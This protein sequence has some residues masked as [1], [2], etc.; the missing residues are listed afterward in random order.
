MANVTISLSGD[1]IEPNTTV[2]TLDNGDRFLSLRFGDATV[3]I[4]GLNA[5]AAA[6]ARQ[7]AQ[8]LIEAAD[9]LDQPRDEVV[10]L[11]EQAAV[12]IA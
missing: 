4:P 12:E 11:G 8:V 9:S 3:I 1:D 7:V 2:L 5:E 6:Y 10:G